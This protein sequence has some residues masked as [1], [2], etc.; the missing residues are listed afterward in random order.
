MV[1]N[2]SIVFAQGAHAY[3]IKEA[4]PDG[5]G[6]VVM[7]LDS[8][9]VGKIWSLPDGKLLQ[10]INKKDPDWAIKLLRYKIQHPDYKESGYTYDFEDLKAPDSFY[11]AFKTNG[12]L[13]TRILCKTSTGSGHARN[14]I[15]GKIATMNKEKGITTVFITDISMPNGP[16]MRG[17]RT[18]LATLPTELFYPYF[19]NKG[20]WVCSIQSGGFLINVL[21]GAITRLSEDCCGQKFSRWSFNTDET[22]VSISKNDEKMVLIDAASGKRISEIN[23]PSDIRRADY[24]VYP[25]SDGNSFIYSAGYSTQNASRNKAWLVTLGKVIE[26]TD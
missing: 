12:E 10:T 14:R 18:V 6:E 24:M 11:Y 8:S 16:N 1:F 26:L 17:Q 3:W 15:T 4:Y 7:T 19:S 21:S 9:G 5:K 2:Q 13:V 22:T 23:V 20:T 25:C